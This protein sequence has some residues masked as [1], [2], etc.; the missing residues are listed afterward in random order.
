MELACYEDSILGQE[1]ER[2]YGKNATIRCSKWN[3]GDLETKEGVTH[4]KCMIQ[5][6]R[7]VHLWISCDCSPYCPLQRINQRSP[8][9]KQRLEEKRSQVRKQYAGAIE[10]ADFAKSLNVQVHWELAERCEAWKLA[11]IEEFLLRHALKK[12]TC[13]GCAVGLKTL[14]GKQALC[15]GWSIATGNKELQQH[16]ELRCQR[17]HPKGR[18]EGGQT[19]HTARYTQPFAKKVI[20]SLSACETWSRIV[21]NLNKKVEAALPA[22]DVIDVDMQPE[23][24]EEDK[25]EREEIEKKIA[26]IHRSTGHGSIDNLVQALQQRGAEDKVIQIA[27][28]WKCPT[29]QRYQRRD[30][31]RF[32]TL[33]PIPQKW[34]RIQAD[35]AT[36]MHPK[37]KVKYYILLV[38][39]EGSRFRIGKVVSTGEG[40][41]ANWEDLRK[42]LEEN[43]FGIFGIP[44]VMKVDPAGPWMSQAAIDYLDERHVEHYSIPAEAHWTLGIVEG[45]IKT[46][47]GILTKLLEEFPN[48]SV[49]E[50]VAR[51]AW[52]GNN[53][54]MVE[55]YTPAQRVFG[56]APDDFGRF[57][58]DNTEVPIHPTLVEDGGFR[59]DSEV[60]KVAE[61][62]FLE[63]QSKRRIERAQRMG[64]RRAEIFLPGDL[65]YIWRNQV[66]KRERTTQKTGK[67]IGPAR[68]LATE[69]RRE[70]DGQLRPGHV[71]WIHKGG[72]LFK[73]VPE[74]LRKASPYEQMVEELQ[75]PIDLPWTITALA[76]TE[77][78]AVFKTF[79]TRDHLMHNGKMHLQRKMNLFKNHDWEDKGKALT[80]T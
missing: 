36:W 66:P 24:S 47:K 13:H 22:E 48:R 31:R 6:F 61:Q 29:C 18:C 4:A 58:K 73:T 41:T 25:R 60:R 56:R 40:N 54:E 37:T 45:T 28:N 77:S 80:D 44:K 72:R 68:V 34:E 52:T 69:T 57:F 79:L 63:E 8:Q 38:V 16:L 64:Y 15:K 78:K 20:D 17:N 50:L 42:V 71:V 33:D 39:D 9:Q 7:P 5:R 62:T 43:W 3:G 51:A 70:P 2:R 30:P 55:G 76:S 67:F 21:D 10:V 49:E 32:A 23:E 12:V 59:E 19:A 27:K 35:V 75:G 11:E 65:V 26:H 14:D 46:F 1:V 53:M 74:Q